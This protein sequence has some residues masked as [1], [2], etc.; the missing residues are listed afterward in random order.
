MYII[1]LFL[2]LEI[3]HNWWLESYLK[4]L[5]NLIEKIEGKLNNE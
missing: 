3:V 4:D 2:F 1:I 5:Y